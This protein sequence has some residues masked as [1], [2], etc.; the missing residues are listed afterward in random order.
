VLENPQQIAPSV[1]IAS[2]SF[3]GKSM[4]PRI[5]ASYSKE[6]L[7]LMYTKILQFINNDCNILLEI[8]RKVLRGTGFEIL[9]NSIWTE[10]VDAVNKRLPFIFNLGNPN[11]FHKVFFFFFLEEKKKNIFL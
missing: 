1:V 2:R 5:M 10:V 9:V 4:K 3:A 7:A 8:T 11:I 6:P